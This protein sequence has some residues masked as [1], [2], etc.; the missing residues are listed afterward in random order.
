MEKTG[1]DME[2]ENHMSEEFTVQSAYNQN[3][4]YK[5]RIPYYGRFI[6]TK[7]NHSYRVGPNMGRGSR[8]IE[9]GPNSNIIVLPLK[10]LHCEKSHD[11]TDIIIY[12][13]NLGIQAYYCKKCKSFYIFRDLLKEWSFN[14]G[15]TTYQRDELWFKIYRI[16]VSDKFAT[17]EE[18][19]NEQKRQELCR[20]IEEKRKHIKE[21]EWKLRTLE[22]KEQK[23][24]ERALKRRNGEPLGD[25]PKQRKRRGMFS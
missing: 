25:M 10:P 3:I 8:K 12:R 6:I 15:S 23:Q 7:K 24:M 11:L 1:K 22:E 4:N 2:A 17:L 21:M 16:Y 14:L 19:E 5:P 9:I 20:M 13:Y 18:Y